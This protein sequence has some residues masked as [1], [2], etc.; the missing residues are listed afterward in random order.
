M[1]SQD[2]P[3]PPSNPG[4]FTSYFDRL[5]QTGPTLGGNIAAVSQ[6]DLLQMGQP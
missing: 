4:R 3:E 6:E 1:R 2:T 5:K